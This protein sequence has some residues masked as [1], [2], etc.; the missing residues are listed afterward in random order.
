VCKTTSSVL[1]RGHFVSIQGKKASSRPGETPSA[2]AWLLSGRLSDREA[3]L[4][5]QPSASLEQLDSQ[6]GQSGLDEASFPLIET[7]G[8]LSREDEA[9]VHTIMVGDCLGQAGAIRM[10][11]QPSCLILCKILWR[12]RNG[13]KM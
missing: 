7:K 12:R 9:V 10:V 13:G 5:K 8:P 11:L 3:S 1:E 4:K 2:H 6:Q